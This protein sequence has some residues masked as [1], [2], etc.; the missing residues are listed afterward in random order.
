MG[1]FLILGLKCLIGYR[2]ADR[3]WQ[4]WLNHKHQYKD[5]E[6]YALTYRTWKL[7][8]VVPVYRRR[9]QIKRL[10]VWRVVR[11]ATLGY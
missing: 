4:M 10:E 7:F 5:T 2:V 11:Q 8:W 1:H 6:V 9:I 3:S